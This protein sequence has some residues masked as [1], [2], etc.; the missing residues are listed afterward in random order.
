MENE[1]DAVENASR[2]EKIARKILLVLLIPGVLYAF[3][4]PFT[5]YWA[6]IIYAGFGVVIFLVVR[7]AGFGK[8]KDPPQ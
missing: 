1:I 6:D 3:C 7:A 4:I 5:P 2:K 8:K